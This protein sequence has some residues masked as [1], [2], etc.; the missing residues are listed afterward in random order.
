MNNKIFLTVLT[1]LLALFIW[2]IQHNLSSLSSSVSIPITRL[3]EQV[4][5]LNDQLTETR[6]DTGSRIIA[7]E[8]DTAVN[9][10]DVVELKGRVTK[11]ED[12]RS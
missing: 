6:I 10:E 11:L 9:R 8:K 7:V 5:R 4:Q 12:D 1:A 3:T 2:L